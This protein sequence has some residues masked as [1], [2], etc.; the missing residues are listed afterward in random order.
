MEKIKT[1]IADDELIIRKGLKSL[2]QKDSDIEIIGEAE[3]GEK[4]LHL[5]KKEQVD[6]ILVDI[7][8]PFLNGLKLIE[9]IKE[10]SPLTYIII[11]SGFN[12]FEYA[13]KAIQLGV[14]LYLLKPI[15]EEKFYL[16]INNA[17]EL[18]HQNKKSNLYLNWAKEEIIKNRDVLVNQFLNNLLNDNLDLITLSD[19]LENL[20]IDFNN[21]KNII[22][23]KCVVMD[24]LNNKEALLYSAINKMVKDYFNEDCIFYDLGNSKYILLQK[25]Y[26]MK[27]SKIDNFIS[28][29][30]NKLDTKIIV[31]IK[32]C[33]SLDSF[34]DSVESLEIELDKEQT[35]PRILR[36][37]IVYLRANYYNKELTQSMICEE[38]NIS[39]QYLSRLIKKYMD[40]TFIH[41]LNL[42]R[43]EESIH[44]LKNTDKMMYEIAEIVGYSSQHYFSRAFKKI[45]KVS[46]VNYQLEL[47]NG[48][49]N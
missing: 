42:L 17:K 46:P 39:P 12:E 6:L 36:N 25:N 20:K 26:D 22:M 41:Y 9:K 15:N 4:A 11:I 10:I 30:E 32:K 5:I 7:N 28:K 18:I 37:M 48:E 43:I 3:D 45:M 38:L 2:I 21:F 33:N 8:M 31:R 40:T 35:F 16:E 24:Q 23:F 29:L 19:N 13:Q 34:V 47:R 44:L 27:D 49:K 1:L 14:N